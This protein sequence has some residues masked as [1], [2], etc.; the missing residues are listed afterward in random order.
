M[1]ERKGTID[2]FLKENSSQ[3]EVKRAVAA[4]LMCAEAI[5][6]EQYQDIVEEVNEEE[7]AQEKADKESKEYA[8]KFIAEHL[9]DAAHKAL[10]NGDLA[11]S[12]AIGEVYN[13][14]VNICIKAGVI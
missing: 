4:D 9:L 11:E 7:L 6:I 1:L 3:S 14:W 2:K 8:Y 5:S 13:D 10:D 12:M